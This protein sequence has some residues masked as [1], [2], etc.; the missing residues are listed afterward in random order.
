GSACGDVIGGIAPRATSRPR[1][2]RSRR[3]G[4]GHSCRVHEGTLSEGPDRRVPVRCLALAA[5]LS[6]AALKPDH[7]TVAE[8]NR[9]FY[10]RIADL[11]DR[12]ETCVTDRVAQDE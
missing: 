12:T 1:P 10:A 3:A 6:C 11:Y 8:A 2:L 4:R 5:T 7:A 9:R